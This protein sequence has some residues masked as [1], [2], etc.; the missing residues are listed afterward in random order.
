MDIQYNRNEGYRT[1]VKH[2]QY[3]NNSE[4]NSAEE[5]AEETVQLN[6]DRD[7]ETT[8]I[9]LPNVWSL[10]PTSEEYKQIVE[11]Y[12]NFIDNPPEEQNFKQQQQQEQQSSVSN[13]QKK[14]EE[15]VK[16]EMAETQDAHVEKMETNETNNQSANGSIEI[17]ALKHFLNLL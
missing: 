12:K 10:L 4:E 8:V 15:N 6:E 7:I 1:V 3:E 13:D 11:A 14:N 2:F 5:T 9:F 17:K 16:Q